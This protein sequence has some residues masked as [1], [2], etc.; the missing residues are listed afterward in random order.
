MI[1]F[2]F[3]LYF[4]VVMSYWTVGL[5]GGLIGLFLAPSALFAVLAIY[6]IVQGCMEWLGF[7]ERAIWTLRHPLPDDEIEANNSQAYS[8]P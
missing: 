3:I 7:G 4:T 2:K 8:N 5:L 1:D 6:V